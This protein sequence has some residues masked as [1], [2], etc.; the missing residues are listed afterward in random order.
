DHPGVDINQ[1]RVKIDQPG[2][3][4]NQPQRYI[5]QTP[6]IFAPNRNT[7]INTRRSIPFAKSKGSPLPN[8]KRIMI[9]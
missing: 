3:D 6:S 1:L 5:N 9:K 4:I 7:S 2:V 8:V